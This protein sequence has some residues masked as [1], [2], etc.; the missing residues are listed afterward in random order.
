MWARYVRSQLP[1]IRSL[2]VA[3][4]G[5]SSRFDGHFVDWDR[6]DTASQSRRTLCSALSDPVAKNAY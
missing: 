3:L 6:G 5:P 2:S 4:H 1:R